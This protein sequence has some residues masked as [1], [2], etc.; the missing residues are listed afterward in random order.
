VL[1]GCG[2]FNDE[3]Y[4]DVNKVFSTAD[5]EID[6]ALDRRGFASLL[7]KTFKSTID[8]MFDISVILIAMFKVRQQEVQELGIWIPNSR[9]SDVGSVATATDVTI[10]AGGTAVATITQTPDV[11]QLQG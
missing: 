6:A 2:E 7:S 10:S 8:I 9:A 3:C 5:V 4:Q 1:D 11:T